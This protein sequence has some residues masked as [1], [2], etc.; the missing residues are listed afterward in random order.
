ML[1]TI[2]KSFA[3]HEIKRDE[4]LLYIEEYGKAEGIPILFLHGGPGS[5]CSNWQKELFD[6]KVYRVIFLDQRGAGKSKPKRLLKNNTISDL[7][8]DLEYIRKYL[9]IDKWFLVGGS[10]GSTL[11][12]AYGEKHPDTVKGMVLRSL[13]L[14]TDEEVRW[15][16][17]EGPKI[18]KPQILKELN[19]ILN[20]KIDANPIESLGKMLESSNLEKVCIAAELWQEY[21]KNLSTIKSLN[22][23]FNII[24]KKEDDVSDRF[25][26]APNTPFL[27]NYYIKN[28]F[29]LKKN[30]LLNNKRR[31]Q[32]I[33]ISI[34]QAQY[35]LL[36]PPI[37][38]FLFS[39]NLPKVKIIKA[40]EA[41]HYISDP[42][43]KKLMKKEIDGLQ[44]F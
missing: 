23:N 6:H 10:W 30:Q 8:S 38:S 15:A 22:F 19:L 7:I 41:G 20:N 40:D 28:N 24:L 18:F 5:G 27:E 31:L 33:P 14:G 25:K 39:E 11:A 21:E 2:S 34:I 17:H 43:I 42:G 12:I 13:F 16:F 3:T 36:C 32:N 44:Y 35:D 29:F 26:K 1:Y 37:N 4:H 9:K